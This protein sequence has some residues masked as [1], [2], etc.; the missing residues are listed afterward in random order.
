MALGV[1]ALSPGVLAAA[2][3]ELPTGPVDTVFTSDQAELIQV[4]AE[5][6]IP[7]TATPGAIGAGVPE[8]IGRLVATTFNDVHQ[9]TFLDGLTAMNQATL[10]KFKTNLVA[11][12]DRQRSHIMDWLEDSTFAQS[13]ESPEFQAYKELKELTVFGYYTSEIGAT[14]E[15]QYAPVPGAYRGN[16]PLKEVGKTWATANLF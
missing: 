8:F 15:L 7:T 16:L 1:V 9:Q 2:T 12:D 3:T 4:L 11:A 13:S 10:K 5:L 14:Q 6:I